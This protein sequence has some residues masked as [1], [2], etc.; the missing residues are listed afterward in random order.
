MHG[1]AGTAALVVI[2]L[3]A[4]HSSAG[5]L[6][7]LVLFAL[8]SILGMVLFSIAISVPLHLS[9]RHLTRFSRGLEAGLGLVNIGLGCWIAFEA[10]IL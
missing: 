8:G 2:A 4:L 3:P 6:A 1:M 10:Q 5:A 9:A 7:Y